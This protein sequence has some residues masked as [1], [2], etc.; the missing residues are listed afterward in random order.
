VG[1]HLV[2]CLWVSSRLVVVVDTPSADATATIETIAIS[3]VEKEERKEGGEGRRK[4]REKREL[5]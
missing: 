1:S 2:L 5:L 3:N 4:G